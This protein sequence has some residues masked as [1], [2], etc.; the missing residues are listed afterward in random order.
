MDE[1]RNCAMPVRY[2]IDLDQRVIRTRCIGETTFGEVLAHF[3]ELRS[4]PAL[5]QPL[6]VRLDFTEMTS[7]PRLDQIECVA[8]TTASLTPML[9]WGAMAIVVN[10]SFAHNVSRIYEA[11]VKHYFQ[12]VRIFRDS[13]EADAW[14]ENMRG[15]GGA[16]R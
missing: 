1:R 11:L 4:N 5:P 3:A 14:L 6:D 10:D 7:V 12:E 13:A 2:A 9:R 15:P 16:G 8:E